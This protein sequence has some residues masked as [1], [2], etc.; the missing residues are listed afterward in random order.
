M[1][2]A[3]QGTLTEFAEQANNVTP[4]L[5][6]AFGASA[7]RFNSAAGTMLDSTRVMVDG[8][9]SIIRTLIITAVILGIVILLLYRPLPGHDVSETAGA[10]SPT[11]P[12]DC[13]RRS[14][15]AD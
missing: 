13:A 11:V 3:Q 12:P 10:H 9:T 2:L 1:Q 15:S 14:E 7:E 5:S 6:R 8:K 4:A